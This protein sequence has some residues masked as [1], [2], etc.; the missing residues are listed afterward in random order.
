LLRERRNKRNEEEEEK[1][2]HHWIRGLIRGRTPNPIAYRDREKMAEEPDEGKGR[3][4]GR[5][6]GGGG[7]AVGKECPVALA[8]YVVA[9]PEGKLGAIRTHYLSSGSAGCLVH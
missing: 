7:G 8:F 2:Q 6:G 5:G 4:G 9:N 1:E 3:V